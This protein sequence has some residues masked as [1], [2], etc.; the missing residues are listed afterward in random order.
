[1]STDPPGQQ[2]WRPN[3]KQGAVAVVAIVAVAAGLLLTLPE[4]RDRPLRPTTV[5]RPSE[6]LAAPSA[7]EGAPPPETA[8]P[9]SNG[10][11][12]AASEQTTGLP[13]SPAALAG[14][15]PAEG[16]FV[17]R[18][19]VE[20]SGET[21]EEEAS[22]IVTYL[23][24][25]FYEEVSAKGRDGNPDDE[26]SGVTMRWT[27]SAATR[28]ALRFPSVQAEPPRR[29]DLQP[30]L[31]AK[32]LPLEVGLR[33]ESASACGEDRRRTEEEIDG[34]VLRTERIQVAGVELDTFVI[35]TLSGRGQKGIFWFA[36]EGTQWFSPQL[37][38]A[39][40]TTEVRRETETNSGFR[41]DITS[42]LLAWPSGPPA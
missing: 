23:D 34:H 25:E 16:R 19:T 30:P 20:S 15:R 40:R 29:C 18:R 33:W 2:V 10:S 38:I 14:S 13:A 17:Y 32:P 41:Q 11:A 7:A 3:R 35:A 22:W 8:A 36:S 26:S 39:V 31:L 4:D 12:P 5:S 27:K 1:M 24:G 37:G 42:E 21:T 9:G 6:S 28:T